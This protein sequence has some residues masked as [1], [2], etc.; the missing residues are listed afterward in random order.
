MKAVDK[1]KLLPKFS[2]LC[3]SLYILVGSSSYAM[4]VSEWDTLDTCFK[5]ASRD[6]YG[7]NMCDNNIHRL[8]ELC[9]QTRLDDAKVHF[10]INNGGDVSKPFPTGAITTITSERRKERNQ[11]YGS[12][13][14]HVFVELDGKILDMDFGNPSRIVDMDE[15][16]SEMYAA[17]MY[18]KYSLKTA[19]ARDYFEQY[20][21]FEEHELPQAMCM[22]EQITVL[23]DYLKH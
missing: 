15:Y 12:W 9:L 4:D 18:R 14:F 7:A 8:I 10:L 17:D 23:E 20:Y 5:Q 16:F 13:P 3:F 2:M 21:D 6:E 1:N 19:S 22:F 11:A